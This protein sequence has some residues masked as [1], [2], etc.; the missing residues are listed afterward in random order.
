[1]FLND[2]W[3]KVGVSKVTGSFVHTHTPLKEEVSAWQHS[4][5]SC[6]AEELVVFEPGH[7]SCRSAGWRS[8]G[9]C[10]VLPSLHRQVHRLLLKTPVHL[11]KHNI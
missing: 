6:G 9:H 10:D 3:L 7:L 5:R 8:A 4:I 1:M 11:W 2:L